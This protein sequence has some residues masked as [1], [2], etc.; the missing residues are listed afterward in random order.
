MSVV[1]LLATVAIL[2]GVVVVAVGRGGELVMFRPD[3][4]P[5]DRDLVT[6]ADMAEYRP[7]PAFFGYSAPATDEA[8]RRIARSVAERDAELARLRGQ[9]A[10]LGGDPAAAAAAAVGVGGYRDDP[11]QADPNDLDPNERD[12]GDRD[13]DNRGD[14]G[15]DDDADYGGGWRRSADPPSSDPDQLDASGQPHGVDEPGGWTVLDKPGEPG[16][17]TVLDEPGEPGRPAEPGTAGEPGGT[18]GPR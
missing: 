12:R 14:P 13:P 16:A 5:Y 3:A 1:L 2:G 15:L 17:W 7:P 11:D 4:P 9:V 18:G 8:L 6:A 10:A